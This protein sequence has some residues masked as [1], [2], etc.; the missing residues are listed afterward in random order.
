MHD[1][2]EDYDS[3]DLLAVITDISRERR[4]RRRRERAGALL[5][6]QGRAWDRRLS[7]F[8]EVD[9]ADDHYGWV[10]KGRIR[11]FWLAQAADVAVAR[12]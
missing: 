12:Q 1:T 11:A 7:E 2:L 10:L 3:P 8:A 4:S 6:A 9:A 5:A